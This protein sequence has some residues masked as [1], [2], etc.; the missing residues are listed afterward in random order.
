MG[1]AL[2]NIRVRGTTYWFRRRVPTALVARAGQV[3]IVRSLHTSSA[4]E[5]RRRAAVL[6]TESDRAFEA[7]ADPTLAADQIE[8]LLRRL[9][10][11]PL[12][13]SSTSANVVANYAAGRHDLIELLFSDDAKESIMALPADE[14]QAVVD[15]LL[16]MVDHLEVEASKKMVTAAELNA[17]LQS[18]RAAVATV[19]A[20]RAS[21]RAD[22]A[23]GAVVGALAAVKA[24][25]SR[26]RGGVAE[27]PVRSSPNFSALID[28]YI[29]HK[30]TPDDSGRCYSN[31]SEMQTRATFRLWLEIIGD[32][33]VRDCKREDVGRFRKFLLK[34][35]ASH[36]KSSVSVTALKAIEVNDALPAPKPTLTMKTARRHFSS[37]TQYW[38]W[39]RTR[40]HVDD[41][42]FTGFEFPGTGSKRYKRDD[43]SPD[44]LARLFAYEPW[45]GRGADTDSA[46][47]W[48]PLI[49]LHSGMRVEEIA[50]LRVGEDIREIEGIHVFVV[51]PHPDGWTPKSEAGE[52]VVPIHS[53]LIQFGLLDF[54]RRRRQQAGAKHLFRDL[55]PG[56]PDGKYGYSYSREFSRIKTHKIRVGDKTTFHSF[57]HSVR[58]LLTD[59]DADVIRDAWID[60]VMGHD[61]DDPRPD[62]DGVRRRPSEGITT[63]L[64]RVLP[65]RLQKVVEAIV[66]PVDLSHLLLR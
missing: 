3:E 37:L 28:D 26:K 33:P 7:M 63:Y 11:E 19:K 48:L 18:L 12:W 4:R 9:R 13:N 38:K 40:D 22:R 36:G 16:R 35:P 10:R 62:R 32:R 46:Y 65:A 51:Q 23:E 14:R 31:Q 39:L 21:E 41:V 47:F 66:P 49:A 27:S 60:E 8:L 43:W 25:G 2:V 1:R 44:D 52:R 17:N 50:R 34:L 42:I 24:A 57:R 61:A 6:W 56:G 20:A 64:K 29:E 59:V 45:F 55:G 58:T 54:V 15:H 30:R 53:R 5:A